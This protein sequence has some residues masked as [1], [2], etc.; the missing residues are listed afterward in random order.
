MGLSP[1]KS[2]EANRWLVL[3]Y[4]L[5][6]KPAYLRTKIWRRLQGLG[7]VL[8]RASAYV[9]PL[10]EEAREDFS[11]LAQEIADGGGEAALCEA[12]FVDG[13]G[14]EEV[15]AQFNAARDQA[16]AE[17]IDEVQAMLA[18]EP[19][20]PAA[21]A[22]MRRR[23]EAQVALD[24]FAARRRELAE[25]FILRLEER[26]AGKPTAPDGTEREDL[27][28]RMWVTREHMF[29]DR[30]ACAWVVQRFID[31]DARFKFV[32]DRRYQPLPGELRFDMVEGEISHEGDKCSMEVLIDRAGL[33]EDAALRAIAEIV[34]DIDLKDEKFGRAETIGI[35]HLLNGVCAPGRPDEQRL[36]RAT[37]MFNDLYD[38]YEREPQ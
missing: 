25:R 31:P 8:V 20:T 2:T 15:E 1:S 28:G 5:P 4:Q 10:T 16:Y 27:I 22:R 26:I 29:V 17:I 32:A 35:L 33:A 34:H 7:A 12:R 21:V 9:L 18:S 11:W 23:F 13:L 30:V 19:P 3:I 14:D 6:T 36:V 24:H 37:A 38:S